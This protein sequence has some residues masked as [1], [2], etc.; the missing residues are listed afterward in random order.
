MA[1]FASAVRLPSMRFAAFGGSTIPRMGVT[2]Q[3][4]FLTSGPIRRPPTASA[5]RFAA[6]PTPQSPAATAKSDSRS[7]S[8]SRLLALRESYFQRPASRSRNVYGR[9]GG[10]NSGSWWQNFR[11]RLDSLPP[12]YVVYGLI[13]V[14]VAIY[15]L[16]QYANTSWTRFRDPSLYYWMSRNFIV[17]EANFAAGRLHTLLTA[18]F[19]HSTSTH[20]FLNMLGLYFIAPATVGLLGTT[21]FLGLYLGGG[22]VGSL[23]SLGWHRMVTGGKGK[24][25]GSEGASAAIYASLA[26]FAAVFPNAQFLMFFIIP[27]PA[28][29][30]VGG[31]FAYDLYSSINS[32]YS[33]TDS[34]GHIGGIMAGVGYA[35]AT[36]GRG[37]RGG[38]RVPWR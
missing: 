17:S 4:T 38:P 9:G 14:N 28:W 18:C 26:Y 31:I 32:P 34:A 12:M 15:G 6:L 36:R 8:T 21:G 11:R 2:G 27:M 7:F 29:A 22:I 3:R 1:L 24:P 20:I 5:F 13:G 33:Q 23:V 37:F 30:A 25:R 16:W 19:S 35:L 10:G